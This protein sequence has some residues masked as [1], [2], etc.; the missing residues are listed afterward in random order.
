MSSSRYS[1]KDFRSIFNESPD[2]YL[3]MSAMDGKIQEC[4]H[5]AERMLRGVREDILGL[6]PDE[7]SPQ[8]QPNG[9][10]SV[11]AAKEK[12]VRAMEKGFVVFDWVHRRFDG[13]DFW[14]EVQVFPSIIGKNEKVLLVGWREIGRRKALEREKENLRHDLLFQAY[15]DSLTGLKNRRA[16]EKFINDYIDKDPNHEQ[17]FFLYYI[18]LDNFKTI[19]DAFGHNIGDAFLKAIATRIKRIA[20]GYDFIARIGGDEF[21]IVID[22]ARKHDLK[23]FIAE[24]LLTLFEK[25]VEAEGLEVFLG[26]SIGVAEYPLHGETFA[27]LLRNAD[28]ALYKSK[29]DGRGTY[30]VFNE[31]LAQDALKPLMIES[32]LKYAIKRKEFVLYYQPQFAFDSEKLI[33]VEALVRWN[34]PEEGLLGPGAFMPIAERSALIKDIEGWI[35]REGCHQARVWNAKGYKFGKLALNASGPSLSHQYVAGHLSTAIHQSACPP[36]L[37]EIEISESFET[38]NLELGLSEVTMIRG[39]G[40]SLSLDD[41]GTAYSSL[42]MLAQMPLNKL[43]I[44][45]SLVNDIGKDAKADALVTATIGLAKLLGYTSIA[46]GVETK[47]QAEFLRET[48]CHGVQGFLYGRPVTA[49][50]FEN[51]YLN[52]TVKRMH[53]L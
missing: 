18:D 26:A 50:E 9:L 17:H 14:V 19:N 42:K 51:L 16:L 4:N 44:D 6:R 15:T 8:T 21:V 41:Y 47:Q 36:E 33:G 40:V 25:P 43:K 48:G 10:S 11:D 46:E 39:L 34:H 13:E 32:Y 28:A 7:L 3:I 31:T 53:V 24:Y 1:D 52:D 20:S 23:E 45:R 22:D 49:E 38:Y 35:F 29:N 30:Q 37:L 5:A 27:E 2:A 12:I